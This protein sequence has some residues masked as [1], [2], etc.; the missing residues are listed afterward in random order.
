MSHIAVPLSSDEFNR[1]RVVKSVTFTCLRSLAAGSPLPGSY[2]PPVRAG[3]T[4]T[5]YCEGYSDKSQ[6]VEVVAVTANT[7]AEAAMMHP[8]ISPE[9]LRQL[10]KIGVW[11][12]GC[13]P[14]WLVTLGL[15]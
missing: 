2:S 1:L 6:A 3:D 13:A 9:D 11:D 5:A 8:E 7:T 15:A 14:L 4:G 12:E 10:E